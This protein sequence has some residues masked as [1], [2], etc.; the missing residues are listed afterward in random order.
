M[1]SK[2]NL[3]PNIRKFIFS[4]NTL[5][6]ILIALAVTVVINLLAARFSY[7]LD[8]TQNKIYSLSEQSIQ[9]IRELN[10]QPSRI[11]IYAFCQT[12]DPVRDVLR[13]LVKQYQ[14]KGAKIDFEFIDPYKRSAEAQK[15]QI[16]QISDLRTMVLVMGGK[17]MKILPQELVDFNGAKQAFAGEQALT[18]TIYKMLNAETKNLYFL[19]GHGEKELARAKSFIGSDG[20]G[21]K[22]LDLSKQGAMPADCAQL[23]IAGPTRDLLSQETK[24]IEDY[25]D[26][27]GRLMIFLDYGVKKAL[28]P[29]ING[30]IKK[31]GIDIEDNLVVEF[32]NNRIAANDFATIIPLYENH[33]ITKDL[34]NGKIISIVQG[35][36][37]LVKMPNYKGDAV[38]SVI[39]KSSENSWAETDPMKMPVY[40]SNETKGPVPMGIV[41]KRRSGTGAGVVEG[42]L[43]VLGMSTFMN[44]MIVNQGGNLNLFYN[45]TQWLLGQEDRI[46]IVPKTINNDQAHLTPAQGLGIR[47]FVM[48][49]F[50]LLILV[51]GGIIWIRRRAR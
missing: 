44:D 31:W 39:L 50:P 16:Q 51:T 41:S 36:R 35:C 13:D 30:L 4:C 2:S 29:N 38:A 1:E 19:E 5:L 37:A 11:K 47:L 45:M 43:V 17:V 24:A 28:I 10:K 32:G 22:T 25:L 48:I 6:I 15:Y 20:Y 33:E 40:N 23:V 49:I 26:K 9:A 46:T 42:R 21:V 14:K 34:I 8:L 18:R 12:G 7:R 3:I 27:G